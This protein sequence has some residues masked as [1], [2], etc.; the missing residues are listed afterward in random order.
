MS[1]G[2]YFSLWS[3][4]LAENVCLRCST[5]KVQSLASRYTSCCPCILSFPESP[6]CPSL[7][8]NCNAYSDQEF[9]EQRINHSADII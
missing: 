2:K 8:I 3:V 6:S 1:K 5:V 9:K 7:F 4:L